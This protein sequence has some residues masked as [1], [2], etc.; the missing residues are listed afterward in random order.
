MRDSPARIENYMKRKSDNT[1]E[2]LD[3]RNKYLEQHSLGELTSYV[4]SYHIEILSFTLLLHWRKIHNIHAS[5]IVNIALKA[6]L[7][8]TSFLSRKISA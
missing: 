5:S 4:F 3:P 8:E 6:F 7:E 2:H 1:T